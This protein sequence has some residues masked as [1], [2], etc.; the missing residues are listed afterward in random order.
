MRDYGKWT[1][2]YL[3]EELQTYYGNNYLRIESQEGHFARKFPK[4]KLRE[5]IKAIQWEPLQPAHLKA[6]PNKTSQEI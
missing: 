2:P 4:T 6:N 5:F 1:G 3:S